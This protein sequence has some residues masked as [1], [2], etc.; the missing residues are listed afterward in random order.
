MGAGSSDV[1]AVPVATQ[2]ED[3]DRSVGEEVSGTESEAHNDAQP[4]KSARK[5]VK[6]TMDEMVMRVKRFV[7]VIYLSS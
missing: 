4:P 6:E 3:S 2:P 5:R 7:K 1:Q